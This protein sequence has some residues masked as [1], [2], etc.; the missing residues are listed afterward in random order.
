MPVRFATIAVW[1]MKTSA[2]FSKT[3]RA[4]NSAATL[5]AMIPPSA[6]RLLWKCQSINRVEVVATIYIQTLRAVDV[7]VEFDQILLLKMTP[8]LCRNAPGACRLT[9]AGRGK[10]NYRLARSNYAG[11]KADDADITCR[12]KKWRQLSSPGRSDKLIN[13][14]AV[15]LP[16]AFEDGD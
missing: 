10:V 3:N 16:G 5:Y 7:R 11:D 4:H 9:G 15:S 13:V 1:S 8:S 6:M 2:P 12:V 14:P